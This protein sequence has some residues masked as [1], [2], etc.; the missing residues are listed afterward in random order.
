MSGSTTE[1]ILLVIFYL[2]LIIGMFLLIIKLIARRNKLSLPGRVVRTLGGSAIGSGKSVQVVE[3]GG[4]FYILGVG[5]DIRLIA[6]VE[7]PE[8]IEALRMT[9]DGTQQAPRSFLT[10]KE[11]WTNRRK[12]NQPA[13][14][15]SEFGQIFQDRMMAMK[16]GR[17][18]VSELLEQD[19]SRQQ[20]KDTI[21]E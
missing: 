3:V 21:D 6:K 5:E 1:Y 20:R 18:S 16:D 9:V 12:G 14:E 15:W 19:S 7:N 11:W 10:L 13:E 17:K 4:A 8:E 2:A